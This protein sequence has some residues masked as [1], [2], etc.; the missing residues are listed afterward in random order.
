MRRRSSADFLA[1]IRDHELRIFT[2]SDFVTLAGVSRS[3]AAHVLRRLASHRLVLRVARGLW[4][5]GMAGDISPYEVVRPLV[6]PWPAYV[7]LY[8][9]LADYGL[10]QEIPQIIYAVTSSRVR[11]Y[12]TPLGVFHFHHLPQRLLWGYEMKR[13]GRVAYPMAEPEKAFL[14]LAYLALVPRS[15]LKFPRRRGRRWAL[16]A[17]KLR[18]Y[19]ARF[20][21][22]PLAAFLRGVGG[23]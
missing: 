17:Q 11:R 4:M 22:P 16:S 21:F 19:A 15:G 1:V 5:N 12:R 8:S 13:A 7:S 3:A 20:D 23:V 2:T 6:A 9:A 14:D 18:R 10:V